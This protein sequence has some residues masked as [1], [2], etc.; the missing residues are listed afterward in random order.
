MAAVLDGDATKSE[1][2]QIL[3]DEALAEEELLAELENDEIPAHIREARLE[4]LKNQVEDFRKFSEKG[5]GTFVEVDKEKEILDITTSE[6]KVVIHFFHPDFRRCNIMDKH[7]K[8][9]AEKHFNTKFA[10]IHV[11]KADFL[12]QK[13]KIQVLPAVLCF[14][15]GIVVDRVVG[16]DE[17]GN[18]D[19]FDISVL[20]KRLAKSGVI[21]LPDVRAEGKTIFGFTKTR[22]GSSS[23]EED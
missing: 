23:S 18:T 10:K 21:S 4:Q 16:F 14:R 9:L 12:V 13:L 22:S 6:E 2:E 15:E 20:E 19:N 11:E 8:V 7:L 3:K 5:Y 17:L 1:A